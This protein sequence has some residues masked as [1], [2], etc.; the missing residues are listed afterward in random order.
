MTIEEFTKNNK[1]WNYLHNKSF[2]HY[3]PNQKP[4]EFDL[5]LKENKKELEEL[6][7]KTRLFEMKIEKYIEKYI[8]KCST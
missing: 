2:C 8:N 1:F 7:H 4:T 3:P 5:F 6:S